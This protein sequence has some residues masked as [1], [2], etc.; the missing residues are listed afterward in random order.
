MRRK[1]TTIM[2]VMVAALL[3]A[4]APKM[5][6]Q[7]PVIRKVK[8]ATPLKA[9]T[10]TERS[11]TGIIS[12]AAEVNLAFMVAGPIK[13]IHV[14][15]GDYVQKG[16]LVAEI[17]TRDYEI[18]AGVARAQYEQMKAEYDR[19]TELNKRESVADNDYEKAV[20][21]EKMLAIQ[22]K[23][24]EDQLADTKLYAPFSGYIQNVKYH[25]KELINTGMTVATLLDVNSYSV[26]VDLPITYYIQ[27]D[28]FVKFTCQQIQVSDSVYPLQLI[29]HKIK[30]DN[31]QLFNMKFRLSPG[32]NSKI[33]PGMNV[34]VNISYN[35]KIENPLSVP[36]Q[37]VVN[38]DGK[39]FVWVFDSKT[40]TVA[41]KEVIT[42]GLTENGGI[43]IVSGIEATDSLVVAGVNSIHE[44]ESVRLLEEKSTTNIGGLL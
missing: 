22:L 27:K 15:E 2:A 12:E 39:S 35:N 9:S 42:D 36:I 6:E 19:L 37:A 4:C 41:R 3:V 8:V 14:K 33:V 1:Y 34:S 16:Q 28:E 20:A 21:G 40:S 29:G 32:A 17:D 10:V 18:Q 44:G 7:E 30:A 24:A 13:K 5:K 31:N 23:H 38:E 26:E 25:A 11:F 43:R